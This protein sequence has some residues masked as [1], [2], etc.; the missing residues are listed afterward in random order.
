MK[1]ILKYLL[2]FS[3]IAFAAAIIYSCDKNDG[4]NPDAIQ[5][6]DLYAEEDTLFIADTT[7]ITAVAT[8]NGLSYI[9]S[10]SKGDIDGFGSVVKYLSPPCQSGDFIVSCKVKDNANNTKTRTISIHVKLF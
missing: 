8:G 5:F 4:D 1:T 3:F 9:W 7:T 6:T 2:Y 10:A